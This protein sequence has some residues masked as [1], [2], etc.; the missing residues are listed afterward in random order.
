VL[1]KRGACHA[2]REGPHRS[3]GLWRASV[4]LNLAS[5]VWIFSTS[6]RSA[7]SVGSP[8]FS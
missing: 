6:T 2:V 1:R 3:T 5:S 7:A 8:T 4:A